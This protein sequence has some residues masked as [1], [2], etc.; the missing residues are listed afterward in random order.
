MKSSEC[1]KRLSILAEQDLEE[2]LLISA[3]NDA[4]QI[5]GALRKQLGEFGRLVQADER[6]RSMRWRSGWRRPE[7]EPI[8]N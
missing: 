7:R 3:R 4:D 8:A 1:S 6:A 2:R 5:L